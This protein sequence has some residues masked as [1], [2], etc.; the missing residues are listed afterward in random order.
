M[1]TK[2]LD[3]RNKFPCTMKKLSVTEVEKYAAKDME[4]HNKKVAG[5]L[6]PAV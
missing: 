5:P 1:C 4:K 6:Q 3:I 2:N